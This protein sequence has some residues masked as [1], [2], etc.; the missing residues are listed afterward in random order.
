MCTHM[1]ESIFMLPKKNFPKKNIPKKNIPKKKIKK[2][3]EKWEA[4]VLEF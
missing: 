2:K 3:M 1:Q 4:K